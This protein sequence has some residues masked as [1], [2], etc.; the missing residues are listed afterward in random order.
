MQDE[1]YEFDPCVLDESDRLNDDDLVNGWRTVEF[2]DLE[3][4]GI[5]LDTWAPVH[6]LNKKKLIPSNW[7]KEKIGNDFDQEP[8]LDDLKKIKKYL[9]RKAGDSEIMQAFGINAETLVA[10]K[11]DRFSPVYGIST[12]NLSKVQNEF[13]RLEKSIDKLNKAIKYIA[14][15]LII[16][17]DELKYFKNK[18]IKKSKKS[19][20]EEKNYDE[21]E[22]Y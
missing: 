19:S 12:D 17:P 11:N 6:S 21:D 8:G 15:I 20:F 14:N 2:E 16:D 7:R 13:E 3:D 4:D 18:Y 1:S 9:A 10:I 22:S 5:T